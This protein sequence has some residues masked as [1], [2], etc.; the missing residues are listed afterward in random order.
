MKAVV[1]MNSIFNFCGNILQTAL[2][3]GN[4]ISKCIMPLQ[5]VLAAIPWD[6]NTGVEKATAVAANQLTASGND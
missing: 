3:G 4:S 2:R 6:V 1:G 5:Q